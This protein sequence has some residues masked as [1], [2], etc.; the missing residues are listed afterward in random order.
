MSG[1]EGFICCGI[2][3]KHFSAATGNAHTATGAFVFIN[4]RMPVD[5][6]S[7]HAFPHRKLLW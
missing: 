2:E 4:R 1:H 5:L 3:I 7:W 6:F